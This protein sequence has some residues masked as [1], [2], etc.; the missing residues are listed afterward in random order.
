MPGG[1]WESYNANYVNTANYDSRSVPLYL[2]YGGVIDGLTLAGVG[3]AGPYWSATINSSD[4][5]Y[6]LDFTSTN[7]YP[8]NSN[9]L[10]LGYSIRCLAR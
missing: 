5:A 6:N 2:L 7:I 1:S 8:S 9:P 3:G 4:F 10:F